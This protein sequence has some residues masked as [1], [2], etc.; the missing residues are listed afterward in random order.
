MTV[1]NWMYKDSNE[2]I[3]LDRKY[4]L[5]CKFREIA[6]LNPQERMHEMMEFIKSDACNNSRECQHQHCCPQL[7]FITTKKSL[8]SIQ[9]IDKNTDS[10]IKIWG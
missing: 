5:Y 3:R 6:N 7:G 2:S 9:Q 8:K 4:A 1:L 10:V